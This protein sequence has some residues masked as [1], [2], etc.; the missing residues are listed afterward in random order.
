MQKVE[1]VT[2]EMRLTDGGA[3]EV[4]LADPVLNRL[5]S[6]WRTL[7]GDRPAPSR[8]D[9]DPADMAFGLDRIALIEVLGDGEL[10]CLLAGEQLV[11][12][13]GRNAANLL[14]S[15]VLARKERPD[16]WAVYDD[17]IAGCRPRSGD[18]RCRLPDGTT[19]PYTRLLLPLLDDRGEVRWLL[20]A[21]HLKWPPAKRPG[22]LGRLKPGL[23]LAAERTPRFLRRIAFAYLAV[24]RGLRDA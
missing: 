18:G 10:R 13:L 23:A 2:L 24:C 8:S 7:R 11:A 5:L 4:T 20:A 14:G 6:Y 16:I 19:V 17:A 3:E 9:I 1:S 21:Y 22:V 12:A 15:Q